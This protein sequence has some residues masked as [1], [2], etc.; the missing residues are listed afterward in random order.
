[1]EYLPLQNV[2]ITDP[3]F[4]HIQRTVKDR[5][6]PYQWE[7]MNDRVPGAAPSGCVHNFKVA[8]GEAQGAFIGAVFQDSDMY[9]WMEAA[10]CSLA[11]FPDPA[12]DSLL[13]GAI[14]LVGRAQQPDGYLNTHFTIAAPDQRWVNLLEGHE[15]YCAG[16]LIEAAAAHHQAT[17]KTN[18]LDIAARLADHIDRRFGSAPGQD[19]GVPGHPEIE[20]ALF[21]LADET[22]QPKYA[23]LAQH[24]LDARANGTPWIRPGHRFIWPEMGAFQADYNQSHQPVRHQRAAA[25]HAVRA[26]YL[27]SAMADAARRSGEPEMRAACEALYHNVTTRQMYITGGIGPTAHGER[28]T[29]DFDLP[30]DTAYAESCA[31]I[32]LMFFAQRMF[33]LTRQ[34][35]CFH[36][37]E[38]ALR[39]TVLAGM[40]LDGERFFYVNPLETDPEA[41]RADP[42]RAHVKL[43]RQKWFGCACCPPNIA[44]AA[45]S[46]GG[47]LYAQEGDS[48]YVLAHIPSKAEWAGRAITLTKEDAACRL[49]LSGPPCT[50]HLRLP[51][52][53]QT[54]LQDAGGGFATLQHPGGTQT[55]DY[56][57]KETPTPTAAHPKVRADTGKAAL[58]EGETVYCLESQ[59]NGPDLNTLYLDP[60]AP[61][62]RK[63]MDWLPKGMHALRTQGWRLSQKAWTG[64]LYAP[65]RPQWDPCEIIAIP[66]S[67]WNNRGEGEMLVW[68]HVNPAAPDAQR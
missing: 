68:I 45:L 7:I 40:S 52:N 25:G 31:S 51:F 60:T 14:A 16:H 32:G 55:F 35:D 34:A 2:R 12:L 11:L 3:F 62:E 30:N 13:D 53:A 57:L 26:M 28:F 64:Q 1:V 33:R 39:N 10:A 58:V 61:L 15:L 54:T 5:M 8:A 37:W 18:F 42:G 56:A 44:R 65:W 6:I 67:Q 9:K 38:R 48:L 4:A 22:G 24:F 29:T 66:Y 50:V 43:T 47:S 36:I 49:T 41:V 27:Y 21:R 59:D 20:L 23:Q 19:Q 63:E 17:D 46:M